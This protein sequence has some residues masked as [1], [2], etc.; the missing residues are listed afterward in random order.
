MPLP[1]FLDFFVRDELATPGLAEALKDRGA[2]FVI[3]RD[4]RAIAL[5]KSQDRSASA[6][7]SS[8]ESVRAFAIAYSSSLVMGRTITNRR[9]PQKCGGRHRFDHAQE[10]P[11]IS[12]RIRR[13]GRACA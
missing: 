3:D 1:E 9:T 5:R 12:W 11:P 4:E 13:L 2:R 10:H 7:C 6:S 8:S